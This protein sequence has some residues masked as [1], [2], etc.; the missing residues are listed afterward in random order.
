[1][2]EDMYQKH[3]YRSSRESVTGTAMLTS[4]YFLLDMKPY[5]IKCNWQLADEEH[6]GN[7]LLRKQ[8]QELKWQVATEWIMTKQ[9]LQIAR[10]AL[11]HL[12]NAQITC[13]EPKTNSKVIA[14]FP[15]ALKWQNNPSSKKCH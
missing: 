4:T 3:T 9:T 2:S 15:D 10:G 14:S 13:L 6:R 8:G 11:S 5:C 12:Q 7:I 1:M